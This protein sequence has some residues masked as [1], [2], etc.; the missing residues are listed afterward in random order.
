MPNWCDNYLELTGP[1]DKVKAIMDAATSAEMDNGMFQHIA[2]LNDDVGVFGAA[3]EWGTKWDVNDA[4]LI[5][6]EDFDDDDVKVT[7]AFSTAWAPP[8]SI[9]ER[10]ENDGFSVFAAYYEP[11]MMF[12]GTFDAGVVSEYDLDD[13]E[14]IESFDT[15]EDLKIIDDLY[16]V[17][18]MLEELDDE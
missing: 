15:V 7:L 17:R 10:L 9:Y 4:E 16:G 8:I 6:Y 1:R 3:E 2:P 5:E 14:I 13:D 18:D 11:G 12:C